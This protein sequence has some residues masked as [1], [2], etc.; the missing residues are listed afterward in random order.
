M[1]N[2]LNYTCDGPSCGKDIS[3]PKGRRFFLQAGAVI[4]HMDPSTVATPGVKLPQGQFHF[5][6]FSCMSAWAAG[7]AKAEAACIAAATCNTET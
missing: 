4:T 7:Q 1:A 5:C 2:K 6:G 3:Q